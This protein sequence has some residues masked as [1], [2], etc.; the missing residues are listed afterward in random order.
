M[1]SCRNSPVQ[2]KPQPNHMLLIPRT[3]Q[4]L[5]SVQQAMSQL[6]C[7]FTKLRHFHFNKRG[8][9]MPN[10]INCWIIGLPNFRPELRAAGFPGYRGPPKLYPT[11]DLTDTHRDSRSGA[12]AKISLHSTVKTQ[13]NFI[14]HCE[15]QKRSASSNAELTLNFMTNGD[16]HFSA[17]PLPMTMPSTPAAHISYLQNLK[18][19]TRIHFL[20]PM[21]Q[22]SRKARCA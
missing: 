17:C 15:D 7:D 8:V 5:L 20:S 11:P 3:F 16:F 1:I 13:C 22:I 2:T 21:I 4:L 18:L 10:R 19:N 9:I 12:R 6:T 14:L